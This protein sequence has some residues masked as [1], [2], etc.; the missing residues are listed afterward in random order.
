MALAKEFEI[1]VGFFEPGNSFEISGVGF[2]VLSSRLSPGGHPA[3]AINVSLGQKEYLV[4]DGNP[5]ST[6][7]GTK[8]NNLARRADAVCLCSHSAADSP[9]R[10]VYGKDTIVFRP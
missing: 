3:L 9:P 1:G 2:T 5:A 7:A 10:S 8:F 6:G 4:V